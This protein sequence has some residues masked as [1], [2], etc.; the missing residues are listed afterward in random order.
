MSKK[1][2]KVNMMRKHISH[3]ELNK[4]VQEWLHEGT[5]LYQIAKRYKPDNYKNVNVVRRSIV[6]RIL[7]RYDD[8]G[9]DED[10]I[11]EQD[12]RRRDEWELT[13]LKK[14]VVNG[15]SLWEW[16]ELY[17]GDRGVGVP[18]GV[19]L[20]YAMGTP[21]MKERF[22]SA[23]KKWGKAQGL[24]DDEWKELCDARFMNTNLKILDNST[25]GKLSHMTDKMGQRLI[26]EFRPEV[27]RVDEDV[28]EDVT[29]FEYAMSDDNDYSDL[30]DLPP[31]TDKQCMLAKIERA[32]RQACAKIDKA[33]SVRFVTLGFGRYEVSFEPRP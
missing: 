33:V 8:F 25:R 6:A 22:S 12:R 9:L 19:W 27:A 18:V 16:C 1:R 21:S 31:M 29:A 10:F 23:L 17:M 13:K 32:F 5:P 14:H 11:A 28:P 15:R 24:S 4:I 2:N 3:Q 26:L 20:T 7:E 30:S